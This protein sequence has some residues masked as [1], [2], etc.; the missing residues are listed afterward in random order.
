MPVK[1]VAPMAGKTEPTLGAQCPTQLVE[2][3]GSPF[4]ALVDELMRPERE[5]FGQIADS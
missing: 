4:K 2:D 5:Q 1:V 3:E